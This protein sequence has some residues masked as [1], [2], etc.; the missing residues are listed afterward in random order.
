MNKSALIAKMAEKANLNRKQSEAALDAF[1][2]TITE[3]LKAGDKVQIVGFGTF[4]IRHRE[5]HPGRNPATG[6]AITVAASQT[7]CFKP[8]KSFKDEF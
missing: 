6:E 8:G 7:P 1:L 5:A 2:D 3:T 4:E